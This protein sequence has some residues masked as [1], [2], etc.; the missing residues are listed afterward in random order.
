MSREEFS[1]PPLVLGEIYGARSFHFDRDT[2]KLTAEYST[3]EWTPGVNTAGHVAINRETN[4]S[5][6][7]DCAG[8]GTCNT[9]GFYAFTKGEL[10]YGSPSHSVYG[11]IKGWGVTQ[12]GT[13]GFRSSQ[14][15]I[16]ALYVPKSEIEPPDRKTKIIRWGQRHFWSYGWAVAFALLYLTLS[17]VSYW[18]TPA[19]FLSLIPLALLVA[20]GSFRTFSVSSERY[21]KTLI[22]GSPID[23]DFLRET[24]SDIKWYTDFDQMMLDYSLKINSYSTKLL[25]G[26]YYGFN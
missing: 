15:E 14:A 18:W 24:Y 8:P 17:V 9:C 12:V 1:G 13:R 2:K 4:S 16:V 3:Y 10:S 26:I 5:Y 21:R 19:V 23:F 25:Y 6:Y 22:E 7:K 11:I 20:H